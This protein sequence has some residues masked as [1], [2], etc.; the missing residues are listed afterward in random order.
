MKV[1][2]LTLF[3]EIFQGILTQS[4][5]KRAQDKKLLK[6]KIIN[7]RDFAQG[8]HKTVDDTPYGG[9]KGMVMKVDVLYRALSSIKPK[10]FTVLLS[11]SGEKYN[12][13][14]AKEFSKHKSIALICGHYEGVDERI[15]R[16][17]DK[18]ISTGDY[19]LTGGEIPAMVIIDSITRL[20]PGVIQKD[21][22]IE[23]SFSEPS[24]MLEYPQYTR[25][26]NFKDQK[27]PS[28]LLSGNHLKIKK[29]REEQSLKRTK[30][31]RPDLLK[32]N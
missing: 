10:P 29:W 20:I 5:A 7:I 27:V 12:Q 18:V 23:E 16:Y 11:A 31:L 1:Y 24:T 8:P 21:S 4:I 2:L 15:E 6:V 9:G 13:Q 22:L 26:E 28:I 19:I 25:P 32:A 3:P 30:K 14:T 17:T